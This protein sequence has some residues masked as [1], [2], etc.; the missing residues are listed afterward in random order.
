L[1]GGKRSFPTPETKILKEILLALGQHPDLRVWRNNTGMLWS[2][3]KVRKVERAGMVKA[4]KGDILIKSGYPVRFGLPGSADILGLISPSGR[5]IAI[6][7]KTE[8]GK[9]SEQQKAFAKMIKRMGGVYI[10]A[11]S[12]DEAVKKLE[13]CGAYNECGCYPNCED[14]QYLGR[15]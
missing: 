9:Q 4:E 5:L 12:A 7:V 8:T 14:C 1:G 15:D 11:R 13:P 6:E 10:L 3:A 2:G